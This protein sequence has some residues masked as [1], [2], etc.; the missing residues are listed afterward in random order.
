MQ[1]RFKKAF[2]FIIK[3]PKIN[4]RK[5]YS[6]IYNS[7]NYN[8]PKKETFL[9][10]KTDDMG[11]ASFQNRRID[12]KIFN[13]KEIGKKPWEK[14]TNNNIYRPQW[15][16]NKTILKK[17]KENQIF[18]T[19][20]SFDVDNLNTHKRYF[21]GKSENIF[22]SYS[23]AKNYK[24]KNELKKKY[25]PLN[26]NISKIITNTKE[27]CFN[28]FMLDLLKNERKKIA[29]NELGYKTSLKTEDYILTQDM[30][31]FE[32]YKEEEKTKLKNLE[33]ELQK[34]INENGA[35]FELMK[36]YS[37]EHRLIL[38]EI[39]RLI[40]N[41]IKFKNYA[42]FVY[43]ILGIDFSFLK[44]CDMGEEKMSSVSLKE[45]EVEQVIKK[46]YNQTKKL[47]DKNFE[48]I[49][50]ELKSD[51]LKIDAVIINKEY[52]VLKLLA[53][54]ENITFERKITKRDFK[55]EM[56]IYE[57]KYNNYMNEY[58]IYLEEFQ[59]EMRKMQTTEPNKKNN[60][61]HDYLITLF[62][63]IKRE[64]IKSEKIKKRNRDTLLYSNLVIPCIKELQ[65]KESFIN[66]LI[67]DMESF[68]ETDKKLFLKYVTET[69]LG[70]KAI[71]FYE[72]REALKMK[73]VERR[74]KIVKKI[75]QIIITGKYKY[76]LPITRNKIKSFS[77]ENKIKQNE[78][79]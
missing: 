46:I 38:G 43:K 71:K 9:T 12:E 33:M 26:D 17:I 72:E 55:K 74:A 32:N 63:D 78:N 35:I 6:D 3:Y 49:I 25:P 16:R 52:M 59:S 61:F 79:I 39:K 75:N 34:K 54:K 27:L 48:D 4:T 45:N 58:T 41:I 29:T 23:T 57:N 40:K 64:L 51:P 20:D 73:E 14:S 36:Q 77:K 62:Y 22:S 15:T 24:F 69:K 21:K 8:I 10:I 53:E 56:E 66:K 19:L 70:N 11:F 2:S 65:K 44:K 5:K 30:K 37:L 18:K 76:K 7:T 31:N 68:E 67:K 60:D 13:I 42:L 1:K 47:F 28:N 50:Q